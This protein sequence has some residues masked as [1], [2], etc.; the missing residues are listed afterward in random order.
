MNLAMKNIRKSMLQLEIYS[1]PI[2]SLIVIFFGTIIGLG[3]GDIYSVFGQ[4]EGTNLG[5]K[6]ENNN[7]LITIKV[8][9]N[10]NNLDIAKQDRLNVIGYLNGE[11][12]TK[13]IDLKDIGRLVEKHPQPLIQ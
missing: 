1:F 8:K 9:M 3:G 13:Y 12:Q 4:T 5:E 11:G 10:K 6:S 2:L 7:D